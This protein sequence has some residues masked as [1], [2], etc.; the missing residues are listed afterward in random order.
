MTFINAERMVFRYQ[1]H[2]VDRDWV[3][4]GTRRLAHY[5]HIPPGSYTFSVLAANSDGVWTDVPGYARRRCVSPLL[6]DL[7]VPCKHRAS[8]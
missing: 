1:L 5:A 6:A 4:A 7:D 2:G 3:Y 8:Q